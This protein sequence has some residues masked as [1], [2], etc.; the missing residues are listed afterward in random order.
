MKTTAKK[1]TTASEL[2]ADAMRLFELR[3][4]DSIPTVLYALGFRE[5]CGRCGGA[6]R[7]SYCQQYGDRCFGCAGRGWKAA[8]LTRTTLAAAATKVAAGELAEIRRANAEQRAAKAEIAGLVEAARAV[9]MVIGAE[10]TAAGRVM[11]AAEIVESALFRAQGLNNALFWDNVAQIEAE[12]ARGARRDYIAAK[13]EIVELTA[14]LEE[15]RSAWAAYRV[16]AA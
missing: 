6:G 16:A 13:A 9:Y 10:Y 8:K 7:Y 4:V 15:L 3:K 2:T 14:Q 11:S 5:A 12:V 1:A